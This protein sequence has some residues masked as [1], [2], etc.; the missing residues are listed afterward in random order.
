[1]YDYNLA[2]GITKHIVAVETSTGTAIQKGHNNGLWEILHLMHNKHWDRYFKDA[3]SWLEPYK[4]LKDAKTCLQLIRQCELIQSDNSKEYKDVLTPHPASCNKTGRA[5][6]LYQH[7]VWRMIFQFKD[8]Y[9]FVTRKEY[10]R[11]I[12]GS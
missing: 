2:E 6:N 10:R 5:N 8:V 11:S 1:M 12:G 7:P 9:E 3:R 4:H